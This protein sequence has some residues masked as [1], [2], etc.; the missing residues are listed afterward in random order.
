MEVERWRSVAVDIA[1][2][3][4]LI[5][6]GWCV[7]VADVFFAHRVQFGTFILSA[8]DCRRVP[9]NIIPS[10]SFVRCFSFGLAAR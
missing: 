6:I 8:I 9:H 4:G 3:V 2:L 10:Y 7:N 1:Q 5:P